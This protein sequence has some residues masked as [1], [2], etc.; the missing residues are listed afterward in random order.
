MTR[1]ILIALAIASFAGAGLA[2]VVHAPY[3]YA[4]DAIDQNRAD[5]FD[6]NMFMGPP[7]GKASACFMRRYDAEHLA[8]HP[9][10]KTAAMRLLVAAETAEG[11]TRLSYSFYLGVNFR[12]RAGDFES[13]GYC[14]HA[15]AEDNGSE[16]RFA[17]GVDCEGGGIN[18]ALS[19]NS[20]SATVRLER[21]VVWK[22]NKPDP[23]G[24]AVLAGADD[25][26]FRLDRVDAQECA[27]LAGD[28]AQLAALRER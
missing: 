22:N 4:Q 1:P 12:D 26:I 10:Q 20:K 27:S 28:S 25:K 11:E 3:A 23:D 18:V 2:Q 7:G 6:E 15:R 5:T 14:D 9:K 8:R 19:K 17:C 21:I 13:S 24:D 16:I